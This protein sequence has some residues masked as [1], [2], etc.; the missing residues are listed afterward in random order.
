MRLQ[1]T[2]PDRHCCLS[3]PH[4]PLTWNCR[5]AV[6]GGTLLWPSL[7]SIVGS[8]DSSMKGFWESCCT[9][10]KFPEIFSS[11]ANH[12]YN[13]NTVH[14]NGHLFIYFRSNARTKVKISPTCSAAFPVA[15]NQLFRPTNQLPPHVIKQQVQNSL[16][17]TPVWR[18][19]GQTVI[20]PT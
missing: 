10:L 16:T 7:G 2:P 13:P 9:G 11:S 1:F 14:R 19:R 4:R 6:S 15:L 20:P 12:T 8:M 5:P 17:A 18:D 3:A